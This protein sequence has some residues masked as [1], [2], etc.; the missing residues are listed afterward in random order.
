MMVDS[1]H[2]IS[3]QIPM[4]SSTSFVLALFIPPLRSRLRLTAVTDD[5]S[6]FYIVE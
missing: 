4:N 2:L 3:H 6:D 1:G 5:S